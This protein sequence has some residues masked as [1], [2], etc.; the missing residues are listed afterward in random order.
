MVFL[1]SFFIPNNAA[2]GY[3]PSAIWS[4]WFPSLPVCCHFRTRGP[5]GFNGPRGWHRRGLGGTRTGHFSHHNSRPRPHSC[6][7]HLPKGCFHVDGSFRARWSF[8]LMVLWIA[9]AGETTAVRAGVPCTFDT[10]DEFGDVF[11]S[12]AAEAGQCHEAQAIIAFGWLNFF[13]LFAWAIMLLVLTITSHTRGNTGV[14]T[15]PVTGT[16]F[17]ARKEGMG[18][19]QTPYAGMPQNVYGTPA[20]QQQYGGAPMQSPYTGT[21]GQQYTPPPQQQQTTYPPAGVATV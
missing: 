16:D 13:I 7:R 19:P 6:H 12:T 14:W 15:Q 18:Q 17:F 11:T 5:S 3:Q 8:V 2:Q 10:F 21:P 1:V 4:S 9:S 20:M